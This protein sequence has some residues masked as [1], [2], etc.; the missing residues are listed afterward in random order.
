MANK[1]GAE[2]RFDERA[3]SPAIGNATHF[4]FG[5]PKTC[6]TVFG[7]DS[8]KAESNEFTVPKSERCWRSLAIGTCSQSAEILVILIDLPARSNG[9]TPY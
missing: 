9:G 2:L 1:Q 7:F 5:F 3:Q 8:D 4:R 6:H